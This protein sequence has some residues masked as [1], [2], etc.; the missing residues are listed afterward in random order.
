MTVP[1][2]KNCKYAPTKN[3]AKHCLKDNEGN[4]RENKKS[5]VANKGTGTNKGF[6]GCAKRCKFF[7]VRN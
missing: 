1:W 3:G 5:K 4:E 2:R 6:F 7:E